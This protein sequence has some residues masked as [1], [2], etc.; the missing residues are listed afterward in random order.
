MSTSS[1]FLPSFLELKETQE[2]GRGVYSLKELSPGTDVI[3]GDPLAHV[4]SSH[5]REMYCHHCLKKEG[6]GLLLLLLLLLLMS[7]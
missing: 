2:Y 7:L 5:E 1:A 4:I 3:V 6:C